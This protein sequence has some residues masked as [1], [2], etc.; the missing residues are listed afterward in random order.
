MGSTL[1]EK[2]ERALRKASED[3]PRAVI[4]LEDVPPDKVAGRVLSSS[5]GP[6]SPSERQDRIWTHLD[7]ALDAHER[8]KI[9]FIVTDTPEEWRTLHEVAAGQ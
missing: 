9:V 4:E 7:D 5:F 1:K 3:D 6:L 8:T 2:V